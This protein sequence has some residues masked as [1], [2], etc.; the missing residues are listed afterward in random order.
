M[1]LLPAARRR[2][3]LHRY[4][5]FRPTRNVFAIPILCSPD[6][7][8]GVW[9]IH[10]LADWMATIAREQDVFVG[11][12][13]ARQFIGNHNLHIRISQSC[14]IPKMAV[15]DR[16]RLLGRQ[17][18]LIIARCPGSISSAATAARSC[19]ETI[20]LAGRSGRSTRRSACGYW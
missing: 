7:P 14:S 18:I 2:T 9:Q 10:P 11:T 19:T 3:T 5:R 15:R 20:R 16:F 17:V 8:K 13:R 12:I 6:G 4:R 1:T